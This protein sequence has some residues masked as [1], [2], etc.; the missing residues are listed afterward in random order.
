MEKFAE[1]GFNKSHTAAY[2]VVS[3]QTAWLKAHHTS[4]FMAATLSSEL[5]NTDQLKV[6]YEDTLANKVKVLAP[7]VNVSN[8]RFEP[9][10]RTEIRYG[11]GAV[12]GTGEAAIDVHRRRARGRRAVPRPVRFLPPGRQAHRQ[13][14]R[15]RVPGACRRI[16]RHQR[17]PREPAGLGRPGDGIGRTGQPLDSIQNSLFGEDDGGAETRPKTWWR[18]RAG[19]MSEHLINEKKSLGF[20]FSGHPYD[21]YR[22]ELSGFIR[23][24]LADL[25]PQQQP[26]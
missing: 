22:K 6:F 11:L 4:A 2:A 12:K 18:C 8:Y 7:D 9:V 26:V 14:P 25:A 3:Y 13:P 24:K 5:D 17:S 20:Y 19:A 1:Y 10:S 16:R 21:A 23:T 15:H